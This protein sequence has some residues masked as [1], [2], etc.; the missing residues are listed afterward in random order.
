MSGKRSKFEMAVDFLDVVCQHPSWGRTRMA[1][2][3][4]FS[5]LANRDFV[6]ILLEKGFIEVDQ[7]KRKQIIIITTKGKDWLKRAKQVMSEYAD[8]EK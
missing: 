6:K 1:S 8:K 5:W 3:A 2:F 7:N 4:N